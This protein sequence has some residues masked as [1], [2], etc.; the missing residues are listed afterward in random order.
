MI[1]YADFLYF[2]VLLYVVVPAIVLGLLGRGTRRWALLATAIMLALQYGGDAEVGE[3]WMVAGYAVFA[4]AVAAGFL[5][6]RARVDSRWSFY[7]AVLLALLPLAAAKLVP[8]A[9]PRSHFG[10]LGISYVTFRLL[11][12]IICTQD[13]LITTLP[14]GRFL[15]Y[16][17]FFG[18]ISAG[19]IDRYRRFE[20][21][22]N[23]HRTRAEFLSDLDAAVHRLFRGFFY[24]FVCAA[25]VKEHWLDP[26][27]AQAGVLN[28]LSYMYAYTVHLFFDFAGYSAFAIA[29]SYLFGIHTPENFNRPFLARN[30]RDF[31][32]RWHITLSWWLRD[33]VYM[34]FVMAAMKGHW[35]K[36][37]YAAS[38]AGLILA[39]GLMG[40]WHGPTP[41][42][43]LYGL[44]HGVLLASYEALSRRNRQRK[45]W[46]EGRGWEAA[47]IAVTFHCVCLGF[48]IFSG[49]L[50]LMPSSLQSPPAAHYE[51]GVDKIGCDE[52]AG[53]AWDER[54]PSKPVSV[55]ILIDDVRRAT[56]VADLHRGDLAA[57]GK[58][59][60]AHGFIYVLPSKWK[61]R[62]P[63][64]V[65]LRIAGDLT[66][67]GGGPRSIAC[68][69][70][71]RA[72]DGYE[73]AIDSADCG[74]IG[75]WARDT[76]RPDEPIRVD[77]YVDGGLLE[78]IAADR[79]APLPDGGVG[80]HGF[81]LRIPE[82]LWD[83]EPHAV[84]VTMSES[85]VT[86]RNSPRI[87]VCGA[88]GEALQGS[89]APL[90][91]PTA[92]KRPAS[93]VDNR[94]GTIT[95][96]GSGLM[97]EK[98][99]KM[100]G[101]VDVANPHDADNCHPWSGRCASGGADCRVDDDCG[102]DR[103]CQ[104]GDCQIE[105]P[106]GMTI[107]EWVAQLNAIK[108]AG[109]DDWRIPSSEE[110]YSIVNPFEEGDPATAA[111]FNGEKCG[112]SCTDAADPA[113]SCAQPDLY[114]AAPATAPKPDD[115][116]MMFFYC[117]NHL[118]L[119]LKANRFYVRAVRR[120][121]AGP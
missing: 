42:Y 38:T 8:W 94:D 65:R 99:I 52:I 72:M 41:H 74:Q 87:L 60:G 84:S 102:A 23:H 82:A 92:A 48:L 34:R 69:R 97:W 37:R 25:L 15:A 73:G 46:G 100:D 36:N 115:S 83:G 86:L 79:D 78:T 28:A 31:W 51:G 47:S 45:W 116:W 14:P 107:F 113:C 49:H 103:P 44:Y 71:V 61:D 75:G 57:A 109:Y 39:F 7:L 16:L 12:V 96:L 110:L 98:K 63:H 120:P 70:S 32:N 17:F 95:D 77:I 27:A 33:H 13:R 22:W 105:S 119:D 11:D 112:A 58:G 18:T 21:D 54:N 80:T 19:P 10:F 101:Q 108:F 3:L 35:F 9:A 91:T 26:V 67:L 24:K 30:I 90:P 117:T 85:N 76:T 5:R 93:F 43:V 118:F 88:Q 20:T 121:S 56:V 104:A 50:P 111:A 55:E 29:I 6:V 114:W 59:D 4:S 40:L 2:G 64:S 106:D 81:T 68:E 89:L 66:D 53:W 62:Q 1:P